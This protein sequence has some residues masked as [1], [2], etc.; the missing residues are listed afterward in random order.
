LG[1]RVQQSVD[2]GTTT[3]TMD[4]NSPLTQV[5]A[6]G[7]NTYLYGLDRIV[8]SSL[9]PEYFLTD[10]LGSMQQLVDA[11]GVIQNAGSF[12]PFGAHLADGA[13]SYGF[14]GEWQKN[15]LYFLLA[16]VAGL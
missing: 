10:A 3:F 14:A 12:E 13:S 1:D 5:L 8:Q 6:D 16:V 4:I 7:T 11:G 15:L 9:T 2:S